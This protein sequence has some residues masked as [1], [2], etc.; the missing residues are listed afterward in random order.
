MS[1]D[2]LGEYLVHMIEA[3][4]LISAYVEDMD[5]Q[6]FLADRRTQQA[7]ILNIIVL[8]EAATRILQDHGDFASSHPDIPWNNMKGMRN[9]MAHGY[10]DIDLEIVWST[11]CDAI[12]DLLVRLRKARGAP[13]SQGR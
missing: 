6:A 11:V 9:R 12:P 8:G 3:A 5:K 7:V 1:A 10:F 4:E 2:R 13:A